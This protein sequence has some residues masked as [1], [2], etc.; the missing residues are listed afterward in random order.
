MWSKLVSGSIILKV[1]SL[2]LPFVPKASSDLAKYVDTY[3]RICSL[4]NSG[5]NERNEFVASFMNHK[6]AYCKIEFKNGA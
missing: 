2:K 6:A 4:I 5:T 1:H 3:V